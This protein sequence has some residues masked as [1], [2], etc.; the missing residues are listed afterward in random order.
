[1]NLLFDQI[2][3]T[4]LYHYVHQGRVVK[5]YEMTEERA[6]ELNEDAARCKLIGRYVLAEDFKPHSQPERK[7]KISVQRKAEW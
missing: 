3:P 4:R 5:S 1:M 6:R 2:E 7:F